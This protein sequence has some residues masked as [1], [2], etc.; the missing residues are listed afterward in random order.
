MKPKISIVVIT[1]GRETLYPLIENLLKQK[2]NFPFKILIIADGVL[3]DKNKLREDRIKIIKTYTR[4]YVYNRNVGIKHSEGEILAFI[5]DDEIPRNNNWLNNLTRNLIENKEKIVTSGYKIKLN[6]EYLTDCISLLG[7]PG[8]GAVGFKTMWQV[9]A[10][11]YT[12]HICTGNFAI[13]K[14][15]FKQEGYFPRDLI[16]NEDGYLSDKLTEK[17]YKIKYIEEAT[18]FH[19]ERAGYINFIKWN[20]YRGRSAKVYLKKFKRYTK[21]KT[22]NRFKSSLN[23]IRKVIK[24]KPIYLP[25]IIVMMLTQYISQGAGLIFQK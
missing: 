18:V 14:E 22:S 10:K 16:G 23:I 15:I 25:G 9:D 2:I 12:K 11:N 17:G 5:D 6:K 20:Y 13:K 3:L 7:F 24:E 8:G 4:G 1:I 19:K 21:G